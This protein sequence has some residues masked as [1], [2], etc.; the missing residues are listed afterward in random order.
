MA[1]FTKCSP[2]FTACTVVLK[3]CQWER[4]DPHVLKAIN[5]E[6][7][8]VVCCIVRYWS[9]MTSPSWL[10]GCDQRAISGVLPHNAVLCRMQTLQSLPPAGDRQHCMSIAA[11]NELSAM[12][13][14][15]PRQKAILM[16]L[17]QLHSDTAS[18]IQIPNPAD[19]I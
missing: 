11:M 14:I 12:R 6:A 3:R 16:R 8:L 9:H 10:M 19:L 15:Q 4:S 18:H 2:S 7:S 17:I 13:Y 5:K 1:A